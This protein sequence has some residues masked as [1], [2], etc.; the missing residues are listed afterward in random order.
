MSDDDEVVYTSYI[1]LRN[2]QRLYASQV[3]LR[4]FRFIA[5][6]KRPAGRDRSDGK[7]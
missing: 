5:K 2:G 7:R 3:G 1:T 6:R 4:V